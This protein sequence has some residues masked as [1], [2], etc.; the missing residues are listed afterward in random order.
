[1]NLTSEVWR[2][3]GTAHTMSKNLYALSITAFTLAGVVFA[4]LMSRVSYRWTFTNKWQVIGLALGVLVVAVVGTLI[5]TES[6]VPV[7]SMFGYALVAG[8][9]GLLLGP[10]TA[11][12]TQASV[13]RVLAITT[14]MVVVLGVIGAV[15]PESLESWGAWLFGG[16]VVLL[17]GYF[18]VPLFAFFGFHVGGALTG[19]DWLG[20][21]LFSGLVIFDLNRAMRI[22][23]TFD[24]SIDAAAA[25]FVDFINIFIRL[26]ALMGQSNTSANRS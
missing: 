10:V 5:Y 7:V 17:A 9:F 20:V 23:R 15:I 14:V 1:M 16:L 4:A 8:P 12:Y 6:D 13:L 11:Q 24:N 26:L 22:E 2:R 19:L 21:V 25:I 18:V 3:R